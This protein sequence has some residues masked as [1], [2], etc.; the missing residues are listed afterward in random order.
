MD[1]QYVTAFDDSGG[2]KSLIKPNLSF[3]EGDRPIVAVAAFATGITPFAIRIEQVE[4]SDL[5]VHPRPKSDS[6]P[7]SPLGLRT[8]QI[9]VSNSNVFTYAA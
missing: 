3:A 1:H 6:R 8:L 4:V 5:E 7:G 9:R 2:T